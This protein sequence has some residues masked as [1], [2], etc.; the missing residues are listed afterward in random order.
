MWVGIKIPCDWIN[1]GA[2]V[3]GGSHNTKWISLRNNL[4]I[5]N[6]IDRLRDYG[7]NGIIHVLIFGAVYV[8][9]PAPNCFSFLFS[10]VFCTVMATLLESRAHHHRVRLLSRKVLES[11]VYEQDP[12]SRHLPVIADDELTTRQRAQ[13]RWREREKHISNNIVDKSANVCLSNVFAHLSVAQN[14]DI[15]QQS[16]TRSLREQG[17]RLRREKER[18]HRIYDHPTRLV[19]M[20][21]IDIYTAFYIHR[22]LL[23]A[24]ERHQSDP[25]PRRRQRLTDVVDE[26]NNADVRSLPRSW[27]RQVQTQRRERERVRT[28]AIRS[29]QHDQSRLVSS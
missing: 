26:S 25:P 10:F 12:S 22:Q 17:Q 1:Q 15:I 20:I 27:R 21:Y 24:S 13:R 6:P 29:T 3:I 19:N 14:G 8:S 5:A 23:P 18:K 28:E 2:P 16:T 7:C 11:Q 4:L 9:F